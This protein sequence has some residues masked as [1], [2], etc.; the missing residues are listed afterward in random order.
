MQLA[1]SIGVAERVHFLAPV[2]PSE[3]ER[4]AAA[5]DLGFIGETGRT[6]NRRIAL[7]NKQFTYLLAGLPLL[8]SDIPAHR[9]FAALAPDASFLYRVDSPDDLAGAIDSLFLRP[10]RLAGARA[11]AFRLGQNRFNWERERDA[12]LQCVHTALGRPGSLKRP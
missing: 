11:A 2:L 4:S 7:T 3:M 9:S 5:Y 1:E 6:C 12:L 8:M 10:E